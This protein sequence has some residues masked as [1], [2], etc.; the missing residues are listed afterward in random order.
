MNRLHLPILAISLAVILIAL[1]LPKVE[2]K[3]TEPEENC[4]KVVTGVNS[5]F[6]TSSIA[7]KGRMERK[8]YLT[9]ECHGD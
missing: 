7:L 3:V 9:G 1:T 2:P 4:F 5:S 8:G 6:E